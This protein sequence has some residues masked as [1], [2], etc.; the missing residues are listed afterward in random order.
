MVIK[1]KKKV[2]KG[3]IKKT[4]KSIKK[5]IKVKDLPNYKKFIEN[6]ADSKKVNTLSLA[7]EREIA[8]D[9]ASKMYK[10]FDR[11]IKSIVLFGSSTKHVAVPDSD[12]DII[13]LIDD[14]EIAWDEELIAHYREEL[15][16][17]IKT[18]PYKKALHINTVKL[19]TWWDDLMRGDPVVLNVI[20]FGDTLI[21]YGG[22][23][24]PLK[25]LLNQGKIKST[26][27]AVYNLI[28]RA[29][30]HYL[31]AK[32]SMLDVVDGLYWTM[33][34][35][36]HAALIAANVMPTSPEHISEVLDKV[37]VRNKVLNKKAVE[38]YMEIHALAKE[39][40]HGKRIQ[41]EGKKIDGLILKTDNFLRTMNKLVEDLLASKKEE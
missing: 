33:V 17:I 19:S 6:S 40:I 16:K 5:K 28:Q 30:A 38:D 8:M 4:K 39:I 7:N 2:S 23:F 1:N 21:D 26:P 24:A 29:P 13:V 36:A 25:V 31:R 20:R 15:A 12:I 41:I 18:N 37:F 11:M 9:F 35:A 27:E 3:S 32:R 22:F 10:E 34:D 14:V